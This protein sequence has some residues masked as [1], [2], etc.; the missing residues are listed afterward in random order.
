MEEN[1]I[2]R[3]KEAW[4]DTQKRHNICFICFVLILAIAIGGYFGI[5]RLVRGENV[6]LGSWNYN[7]DIASYGDSNYTMNF[8]SD[9]KYYLNSEYATNYGTYT[10]TNGGESGRFYTNIE[11]VKSYYNYRISE[12]R[13]F[14]FLTA[15]GSVEHELARVK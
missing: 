15:D 8:T 13:E 12:D 3:F 5:K 1:K 14:L 7:A 10:I 11:G 2:S 9:Y 6:L 4:D